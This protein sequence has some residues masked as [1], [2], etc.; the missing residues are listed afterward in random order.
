MFKVKYVL[1]C[2]FYGVCIL[3]RLKPHFIKRN[4]LGTEFKGSHVKKNGILPL[5]LLYL[6]LV[7]LYSL[8]FS[9]RTLR[10]ESILQLLTPLKCKNQNQSNPSSPKIYQILR[11][12]VRNKVTGTN[13]LHR[14]KSLKYHI[15][16]TID[17]C[18]V[19]TKMLDWA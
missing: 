17:L 15:M 9:Q 19:G 4:I 12:L 11:G 13:L 2:L 6:L 7:L 5:I 1:K 16:Q 18:F 10:P 3:R 8:S 14:I